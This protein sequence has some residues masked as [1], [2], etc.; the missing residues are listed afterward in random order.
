MK[1]LNNNSVG[2][3]ALALGVATAIAPAWA[4]TTPGGAAITTGLGAMIAIVAMWSL[5]AR[6]PTKD[7]WV[8]SILGL[9]LFN[10]P[11]FG[12]F[13]GDGAAWS[14]WIAG[15]LVMLLSGSTY[16]LDEATNIT[17][18][19]RVNELAK[20]M[21]QQKNSSNNPQPTRTGQSIP[22]A[23]THLCPAS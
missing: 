12:L 14:A 9:T 17:E 15:P 19:A 11:W 10:A 8:L 2:W 7:H 4:D 18:N 21:V 5:I 22:N 20:Y 1:F 16:V 13:A 6:D 3:T 23:H